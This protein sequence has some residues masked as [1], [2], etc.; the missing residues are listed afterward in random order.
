MS[1]Y[2]AAIEIG[3]LRTCF[4]ADDPCGIIRKV[5]QIQ[6][7]GCLMEMGRMSEGRRGQEELDKLE[8]FLDKY[9]KGSLTMDDIKNLNVH[10]S[11][12]NLICHGIAET[13]E[14][15]EALKAQEE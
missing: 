3:W 10:L 12:A 5:E 6:D 7:F 8:A 14:E 1:K 9:Y 4:E 2:A 15:V 11:I 13:E